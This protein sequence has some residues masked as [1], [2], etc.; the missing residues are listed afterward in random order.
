MKD[1][2]LF[3]VLGIILMFLWTGTWDLVVEEKSE[4]AEMTEESK[5]SKK[6][7]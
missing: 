4:K 7:E 3:L 1:Y 6:T 2:K 5:E